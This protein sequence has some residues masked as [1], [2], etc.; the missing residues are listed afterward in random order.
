[1][2]DSRAREA[3]QGAQTVAGN[4]LGRRLGLTP[5]QITITGVLLTGVATAFVIRGEFLV[6]GLVLIVGGILDFCDGAVAKVMGTSS[7]FGAFVDSVADRFSDALIL[8][9]L[10]W[11]FVREADD[12]FIAVTLAALVGAQL[13][14]YIR[15][16]AESLGYDCKTGILE[17]AERMIG[18]MA[19]LLL[20]VLKP[21]LWV[22]AVG[23][24]I[25]VVQ[26]LVHVTRQGRRH[27]ST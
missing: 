18:I 15:A 27:R 16:K 5:N 19:G 17:R 11:Y 7:T 20:G 4:L 22:L 3:L 14:S 10:T 21:V 9:G 2:I 25:T 1:M 26:R 24:A 8:A 13:T 12:L 6:A 23:A